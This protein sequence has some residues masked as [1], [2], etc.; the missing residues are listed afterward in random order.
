MTRRKVSGLKCSWQKKGN[1][2][3]WEPLKIN[4]TICHC[5]NIP[6]QLCHLWLHSIA[7]SSRKTLRMVRNYFYPH[8]S[9]QIKHINWKY[10]SC[11]FGVGRK[12]ELW[13]LF[14]YMISCC[15]VFYPITVGLLSNRASNVGRL[16]IFGEYRSYKNQ[17]FVNPKYK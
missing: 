10:P 2:A 3:F 16:T 14:S 5:F 8:I 11:G 4:V 1:L 9:V 7:F 13:V 12:F 6:H 17:V 15:W